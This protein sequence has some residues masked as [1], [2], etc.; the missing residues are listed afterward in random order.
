MSDILNIGICTVDVI[1][2]TIDDFPPPGGLRLFDDLTM[3]TGGNATN[4]SIALARMGVPCDIITKVGCDPLG[5]F[6]VNQLYKYN[7]CADCVIRDENVHTPYTFV[8]VLSSG[9]RSLL[10]TLGTNGTLSFEDIDLGM[11]RRAR[12]C[13]VTGTMLMPALDGEPTARLLSEVRRGGGITLLDTVYTDAVSRDG[14]HAKVYPAL[15]VL[16]YFIPSYPEARILTGLDNPAEMA[17]A[18][19]DQGCRNVIVKLDERGAFCR[20]SHGTE[21]I[22]P[23]YQVKRVV[24]TTGAGDSWCAG[25]LAGLSSGR[26]IAEA[27]L[28]GNATAAHCIQAS[29]AS[30]GIPDIEQ[31]REFQR[32]TPLR[33]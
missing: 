8:C 10:H 4:C 13:L 12:F 27:A 17:R 2:R 6:V 3:T 31:I 19:Q 29:G 11:V 15:P 9:Q 21:M 7:I 14:W 32:Q 16:D 28:L 1:A 25:F 26:D 24:D 30:T 33:K 22:V 20:D 5:D 23:A 18:L